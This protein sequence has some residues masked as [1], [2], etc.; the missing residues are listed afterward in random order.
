MATTRTR[1]TAPQVDNWTDNQTIGNSD[2]VTA[3]GTPEG[4][5]TPSVF[6]KAVFQL[7]TDKM[8]M[9]VVV[10][11]EDGT[12]HTKLDVDLET[13][14]SMKLT[15]STGISFPIIQF[16]SPNLWLYEPSDPLLVGSGDRVLIQFKSKSGSKKAVR[17]M[18]EWGA[19]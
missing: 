16:E 7:N 6:T 8:Y 10:K 2:F 13:I 18:S 5:A 14:T 12:E 9:K 3:W 15:K 19:L 1:A 4:T 11:D 17:G